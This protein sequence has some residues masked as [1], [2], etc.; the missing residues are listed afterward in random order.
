MKRLRVHRDV[1]CDIHENPKYLVLGSAPYVQEW[2][3]RNRQR[4][5]DFRVIPVN[6]AIQAVPKQDVYMWFHAS[7]YRDFMG[8]HHPEIKLCDD[9]EYRTFETMPMKH[10]Y[11]DATFK[12][13]TMV[14]VLLSLL[15][16]HGFQPIE[17]HIAGSDYNYKGEKTHFY[18][19]KGTLDP[20][21]SGKRV[22][23]NELINVDHMYTKH[24]SM[25]YNV[26]GQQ[27]SLLPFQRL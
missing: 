18:K 5:S 1:P 10:M 8:K 20:L 3:A 9:D 25:I 6:N 27:G 15:E 13:T 12:S 14:D 7:D 19:Q 17:V 2:Y 24:N 16:L 4:Y 23:L 26:G 11:Y 22:L 21:R